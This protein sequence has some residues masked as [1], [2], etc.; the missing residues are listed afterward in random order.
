MQQQTTAIQLFTMSRTGLM[1]KNNVLHCD[2]IQY[3][4]VHVSK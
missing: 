4:A 2:S 3:C 1:A